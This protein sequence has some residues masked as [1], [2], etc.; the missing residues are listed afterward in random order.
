M[1]EVFNKKNSLYL[2][3][4]FISS[5][6]VGCGG[7]GGGGASVS[8]GTSATNQ[9]TFDRIGSGISG[10]FVFSREIPSG[11][12]E[13]YE[14]TDIAANQ[15][16]STATVSSAPFTL[17]ST[18]K[19]LEIPFAV[20]FTKPCISDKITIKYNR[21]GS[22]GA[23]FPYE[24]SIINPD[25]NQTNIATSV[26]SDPLYKYQWHLHNTGQTVGVSSPAIMGEDIDVEGVW[27]IDKIT[28]KGVVVAVIDTGV[29]MFHPDL[30]DNLLFDYSYNYHTASNNPTP[31]RAYQS[32][33]GGY[34]D[35]P[36]GTAV[37]GLIGAKGWNGIGTRG[38]APDVS[39]VSFNALE[40]FADEAQ[41]LYDNHEIPN[42]LT[43]DELQLHRLNDA[44][45]RNI[46]TVDIY[47]NSWGSTAISL[48]DDYPYTLNFDNQLKYGVTNGREGKGSI[49]VKSAGNGRTLCSDSNVTSCDMDNFEQMQTNGY[50]IVVGASD[51]DGKYSDYSTPGSNVL[52]NAPGGGSTSYY[53]KPDEQMIVTTDLAGKAR[54]YDAT[55]P[56]ETSVPHFNV[57]GNE[58]YDYTQVMNGTSAA[59]PIVS[60]VVS[61]MLEANPNLTWRDVR[62]ILARSAFKNDVLNSGWK[63]N[64]AGLHFNNNYGF[65]RVNAE[66]AIAMAKNFVSVGNIG[67]QQTYETQSL[68]DINS[69]SGTLSTSLNIPTSIAI[70]HVQVTLTLKEAPAQYINLTFSGSGSPTLGPL[71]LNGGSNIVNLITYGDENQSTSVSIADN[72]LLLN[73]S[74]LFS[75]ITGYATE[76]TTVDLNQSG[77]YYLGIDSNASSWYIS[78]NSPIPGAIAPNLK[79]SLRSPNNTESV[80]VDAPNGLNASDAYNETRLSSVQFMDEQSNGN[81]TL[82]I[83]DKNG[84]SFTLDKWEMQI[85]GH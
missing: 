38:V 6:F 17:T 61:L 78:I 74:A 30:K 19:S 39:L 60:G 31:I 27:S 45:V 29:D 85:R 5:L 26:G 48:S 11:V 70:E 76:S 54:G 37:A 69:A 67:E 23:K 8:S 57:S 4:I 10:T 56:A 75:D 13:S 41:T 62:I 77:A 53:L 55:I 22:T 44:L 65:G 58:N 83:E 25:Y 84:G 9:I 16:A 68:S 52:V 66:A 35:Y 18:A 3:S 20:A 40:V 43:D 51:A 33:G 64:A 80:L 81:W 63:N 50:F 46:E 7:G 28:G 47:S 59:A 79:I 34:Y 73:D 49:Y 21:I 2:A 15:C 14:I 42:L 82:K 12:S 72:S 32:D 24:E 71:I 1:R 36:H